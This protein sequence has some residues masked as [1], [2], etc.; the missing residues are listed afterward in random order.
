MSK[1]HE[2]QFRAD[3][4]LRDLQSQYKAALE[5]ARA[6]KAKADEAQRSLTSEEV[7]KLDAALTRARNLRSEI[8]VIYR[9]LEEERVASGAGNI[10][11]PTHDP[12]ADATPEDRAEPK[13]ESFGEFLYA[14]RFNPADP[15]LQRRDMSVSV[16]GAGGYLVPTEFRTEILKVDP[17]SALVRPRATV[18]PAGSQPDA[19]VSMVAL[20]QSGDKGVYSGV[21]VQWIAEGAEKPKTEPSL[22]EISW[23]PHEVAGHT[24]VT[25]KLLRNAPAAGALV[26]TLLRQAINAAEDHAFISGNGAGKPLG[27]LNSQA[28]YFVNRQVANQIT[29]A[30]LVAMY[31]RAKFGGS[32]V[33]I[34]SQSLLPQLM[35]LKDDAGALIW[36]PNA[37][38]GAPG[39]LLGIPFLLN[40]RSPGL[41][42]K[43]D[44][45]LADLQYYVIK[46][47]AGVFVDASPHV[48][49]TS[50]KTV[51]KAF[52]NV[53]AKPWLT[54][55]L[56]QEN[57]YLVSPFVALDLPS[58]G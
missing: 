13:W 35:S 34:G 25:D 17:Q 43:G 1:N 9:L 20:D 48:H 10:Q 23:A 54:T 36:Q 12:G 22:R 44:L 29:Y 33:W 15:R 3:E 6:I 46:D 40:E 39:T 26:E 16:P 58:G 11:P 49:F 2:P 55:P 21:V 41:G 24:V 52:W 28:T 32:L 7:S 51:I 14:V 18:I 57:G 50:N 37:R 27:I 5:E 56:E 8:D 47:G 4:K 45:I 38:E 53:D 19:E 42:Q 30:D 31:A